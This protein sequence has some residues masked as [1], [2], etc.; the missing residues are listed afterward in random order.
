MFRQFRWPL[1]FND[2][3]SLTYIPPKV[4]Q[5]DVS[6]HTPTYQ[7]SS[8]SVYQNSRYHANKIRRSNRR[9]AKVNT[10]S[11]TCTC[12]GPYFMVCNITHHDAD[13]SLHALKVLAMVH[14]T[15]CHPHISKLIY[16]VYLRQ[17]V[18]GICSTDQFPW[19]CTTLLWLCHHLVGVY[20]WR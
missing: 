1:R 15:H 14:V 5:V 16:L 3:S 4:N 12:N 7:V 19:T 18:P 10:L 13:N 8:K 6:S 2:L 17:T 20:H 9:M 11:Y